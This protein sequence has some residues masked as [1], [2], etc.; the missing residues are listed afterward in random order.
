[1]TVSKHDIWTLLPLLRLPLSTHQP[2]ASHDV[3]RVAVANVTALRIV[4]PTSSCLGS[5]KARI[6]L[7]L[8]LELELR[9]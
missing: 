3:F 2:L 6:Q 7:E 5:A 9:T 4:V 1:L 8:E